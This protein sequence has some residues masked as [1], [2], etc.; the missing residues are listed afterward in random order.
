ME[1]KKPKQTERIHPRY[2]ENVWSKEK[3][4]DKWVAKNEI[5]KGRF[6]IHAAVS[7]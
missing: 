3:L 6:G 7:V 2:L 5:Q 1:K 4:I